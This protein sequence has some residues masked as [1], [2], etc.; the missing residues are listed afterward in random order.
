MYN[1]YTIETN[2]PLV[3]DPPQLSPWEQFWNSTLGK[4]VAGLLVVAALVLCG[5]TGNI[6]AFLV[7]AGMTIGSLVIGASIAG[8]Q[9]YVSGKGFW[10]GF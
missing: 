8:Y 4:V 3:Y 10:R 2:T 1:G 5:F 6:G 7:T 9:S